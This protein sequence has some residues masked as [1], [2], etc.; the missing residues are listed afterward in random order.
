MTLN[1]SRCALWYVNQLKLSFTSAKL[2][3]K[4][5]ASAVQYDSPNIGS[6]AVKRCHSTSFPFRSMCCVEG[7]RNLIVSP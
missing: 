1:E 4:V 5:P 6:G 2:R 3:V 7:D